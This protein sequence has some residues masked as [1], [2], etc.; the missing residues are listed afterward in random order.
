MLD[1]IA[2]A[3]IVLD[4]DVRGA[5]ELARDGVDLGLDD[6]V[7]GREDARGR[8]QGLVALGEESA[9]EMGS[10]RLLNDAGLATAERDVLCEASETAFTGT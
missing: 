6:L 10:Y 5:V 9:E 7:V 4:A 8:N 3:A 1:E 2:R